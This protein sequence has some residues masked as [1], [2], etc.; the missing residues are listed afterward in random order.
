MNGVDEIKRKYLRELE[1]QLEVDHDDLTINIKTKNYET[2]RKEALPGRAGF[3]EKLCNAFSSVVSFEPPKEQKER[4]Q[5]QLDMAHLRC[6]PAGVYTVAYAIPMMLLFLSIFTFAIIPILFLEGI[7]LFYLFLSVVLSMIMIIPFL[8]YPNYIATIMRQRSSNEM[9]LCIFYIVTYMRQ[10]SNLE[11][12]I[13]FAGDH[14]DPPLSLD[15]KRLIWNVETETNNTLNDA[16]DE[17]LK[18]WKGDNDEFIDS[19][20]LIQS[21][22]LES[23]EARRLDLLD[24]SLDVMLDGTYENMLHYAQNLKNPITMLHMLGVILPILGLV[25]LPLAVSFMEGIK[26]THLAIFYNVI[27]PLGIF[28]LSKKI[29]A[30]RP[31][32]YGSADIS[33]ARSGLKK[34]KGLMVNLGFTKFSIPPIYVAGSIIFTFLIIGLMPIL[35]FAGGGQDICWDFGNS[36]LTCSELEQQTCKMTYCTWGYRLEDPQTKTSIPIIDPNDSYVTTGKQAGKTIVGPYGLIASL[37]SIAFPIGLGLGVG[38]YYKLRSKR[39]MKVREETKKLEKEFSTALF[40]LGNR[41]G[42]GVPAEVA[43]P[44]VAMIMDG[45]ISGNFFAQVTVNM[46][47][48]GMGLNAA[49]FDKH[50]GAINYYPSKVLE[51]SM[52][53]LVESIKKGPIVAAQAV[54]NI[55]RYIKEIHRV[56]ER[57]KDLLSDIISSMKQQIGFLAPMI[58]GVVVGITSMITFILI[59]LQATTQSFANDVGPGQGFD[60]LIK[61][62]SGIP[63]YY[64]QLFVGI[65]VVQ[66]VFILTGMAN[67]IENGDDKLAEEFSLGKNMVKSTLIYCILAFI[68]MALFQ[69]VTG[70]ILKL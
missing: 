27:L 41:L 11:R 2:F 38:I 40:Q 12:A 55:A 19:M 9:V 64:F 70:Q 21:S 52:K 48:L 22:L 28:L 34:Y 69:L 37:I 45:T 63:T 26:W 39:V 14:L 4:I 30:S 46:Q 61:L 16:M 50:Q 47:K 7:S 13:E 5:K 42:D 29:L 68:L 6:T 23:S 32:G 57:L 36:P 33:D 51:S 60:N 31:S 25:I 56:D 65:Y 24:K 10:S 44:K 43:I 67:T 49:I 8:Q 58:S 35:I 20:H 66:I 1:N 53:V 17:Y 59:Q 54:N 62:G 15:L 3:F 18:T